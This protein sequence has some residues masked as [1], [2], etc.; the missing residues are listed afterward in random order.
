[1]DVRF[2]VGRALERTCLPH[3]PNY[4]SAPR[5]KSGLLH[6]FNGYTGLYWGP[7]AFLQALWTYLTQFCGHFVYISSRNAPFWLYKL[8]VPFLDVL[9]AVRTLPG[10]LGLYQGLDIFTGVIPSPEDHFRTV[11]KRKSGAKFLS[12][13]S[14]FTF[15]SLAL[16]PPSSKLFPNF[17]KIGSNNSE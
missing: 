2:T 7:P 10:V 3:W 13:I 15:Q 4:H 9:K 8:S 14:H 17:S 16:V 11:F 12:Y 5:T 1:M 6:G